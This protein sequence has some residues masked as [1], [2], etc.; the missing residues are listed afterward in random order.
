M[1]RAARGEIVRYETYVRIKDD[2]R[3]AIDV[4]F[5]PLRNK[6]GDI[7]NIL[8]FGVD[9]TDRKNA[10]AELRKSERRLQ[11]AQQIARIGSW[12]LIHSTGELHWSPEVFRIFGINPREFGPTYGN[13]LELIH[14]DD[15][16]AVAEAYRSSLLDRK[17]YSMVHRLILPDGG[18]KHVEER[19]TTEFSVH[20]EPQI[21]HGTIQDITDRVTA[22]DTIRR[23]LAEKELLVREMH[24]RVKNN[25]QMINSIL[26]LEKQKLSDPKA[27]EVLRAIQTRIRAIMLVH[28]KLYRSDHISSVPFHDYISSLV[29]EVVRLNAGGRL[30]VRTEVR[31]EPC[32]LPIETALPCGLIVVELLTNTLKHAFPNVQSGLA[33]INVSNDSSRLKVS[34]SDNGVGFPPGFQPGSNGSFGWKLIEKLSEQIDGSIELRGKSVT[35]TVPLPRQDPIV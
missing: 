17:P 9:I 8:G 30:Q 31:A 23:S 4:S 28:E 22:N 29:T 15:R 7:V 14:P 19:C 27:D 21:S 20:G 32:N 24:H 18:I 13:F 10:E 35:L 26:Y 5:L 2:A 1:E 6:A 3:I 12:E 25:L 11:Q 34:L 33:I 16:E